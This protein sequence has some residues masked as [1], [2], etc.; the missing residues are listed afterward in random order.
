MRKCAKNTVLFFQHNMTDNPFFSIIVTT[1]NSENYIA[2]T[3]KCLERQTYR[4]YEIIFVDDASTD[5]TIRILKSKKFNSAQFIV[6]KKNFGGPAKGRNLG[7]DTARGKWIV[8][9]DADDF[10]K[11][12]ILEIVNYTIRNGS[13]HHVF[14]T[15]EISIDFKN[16]KRKKL[17]FYDYKSNYYYNM[18]I[19]GNQLS[20]SSTF[21]SL[22]YIKK[23]NLYFNQ[24]ENL[25]SVEDYEFW[26]ELSRL[27]T[28]FFYISKNLCYYIVNKDS[29]SLKKLHN[30]NFLNLLNAHMQKIPPSISKKINIRLAMEKQ[31]INKKSFFKFFVFLKFLILSPIYLINYIK[32]KFVCR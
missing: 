29:L 25:I 10:W 30:Q 31:L 28:K 9:L 17:N 3:I 8:F 5:K 23:N 6:N 26:L 24:S 7:I 16:K 19:Y 2:R 12:N 11:K 20:P 4:N 21:V 13:H 15:R 14:S 27:N 18:L 32:V 22:E 1:H